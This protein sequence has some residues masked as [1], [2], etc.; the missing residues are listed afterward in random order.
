[1][2]ERIVVVQGMGVVNR[3]IL[4]KNFVVN[5]IVVVDAASRSGGFE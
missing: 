2:V 4:T 3:I 5:G 1:M